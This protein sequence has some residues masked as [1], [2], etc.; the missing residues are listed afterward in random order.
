[1]VSPDNTA[2]ATAAM[3]IL[4][5][6]DISRHSVLAGIH[7]SEPQP[8]T[9]FTTIDDQPAS[10]ASSALSTKAVTWERVKLATMSNRI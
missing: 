1:M 2:A 6:L 5:Q 4:P 9:H 3:A 8:G 7:Q 10:S